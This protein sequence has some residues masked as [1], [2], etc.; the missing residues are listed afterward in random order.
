MLLNAMWV[1]V[2]NP[3]SGVVDTIADS[4]GPVVLGK[5][6]DPAQTE[7]AESRIV[8]GSGTGDIRDT[9]ACMVNHHDSSCLDFATPEPK[10]D[11]AAPQS[12]ARPPF[13]SASSD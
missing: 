7:R 11:K 1:K 4:I 2:V 3:E 12:Y 13:V 6:R 8:K 10:T 5:L 9:D